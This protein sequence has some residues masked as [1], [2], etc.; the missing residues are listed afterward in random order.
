V[1]LDSVAA[2]RSPA[3]QALLAALPSYDEQATIGLAERL[4]ADHDPA[5]VAAAL[6]QSRLR[7]AASR[8]LGPLAA[9]LLWTADAAEQASR[10]EV[11]RWRAARFAAAGA[12]RIL[13]LGAGAGSDALAF[14]AEGIDV[15]AV[16]RDPVTAAVLEAN[17][18]T[19]GTGHI[20][21]LRADAEELTRMPDLLATCDAVY[22]DPARRRDGHRVL[23]PAGWSPPLDLVARLAGAAR[24]GA[25]K[26]GPGIAHAAIPAE[27]DAEWLSH[28]GD[29]VECS[30]WWGELRT[31][32]RHAATLLGPPSR[33]LAPPNGSLDG[34]PPVA[35]PGG[36]L[37]EPDGAVI[38]AGL[39]AAVA[40]ELGGWLLD[41]TIAYVSCD[42]DLHSPWTVRYAVTDVLPFSVKALR[43]LLRE[44]GVG[45]VTIKKRGSA[46]TPEQL[47]PQ[48]RL[49]GPNEATVV[50]TRIS[51][52]PSVLVGAPG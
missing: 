40:E 24:C 9:T 51:G 6:T 35:A 50:L 42:A 38:R 39:V 26:I 2:L 20:T 43:A 32:I 16:E 36:Y 44:R 29:V 45:R 31:G 19:G 17:A 8:R 46:V 48:L 1:D 25:A 18:A 28:R 49:A 21:V 12:R 34:H 27:V 5:L 23:D 30:L 52:K 33:T 15:V 47:R 13:D 41:P 37:H 14:A 7:A 10:T 4:H 11:A 3:G 22:A